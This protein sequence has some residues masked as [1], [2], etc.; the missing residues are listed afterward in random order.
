MLVAVHLLSLHVIQ[1]VGRF[2]TTL[3][4]TQM[5]QPTVALVQLH[6]PLVEAIPL[7]LVRMVL[8]HILVLAILVA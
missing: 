4:T 2:H 5:D 8:K 6:V 7:D 1:M 3:A